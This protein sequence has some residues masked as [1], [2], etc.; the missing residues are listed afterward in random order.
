MVQTP[1]ACHD[2]TPLLACRQ[3]IWLMTS[4]ITD[5]KDQI[6]VFPGLQYNQW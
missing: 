4:L 1:G 5:M 6:N 3:E 2:S